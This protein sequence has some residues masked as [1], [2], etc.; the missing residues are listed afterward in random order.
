MKLGAPIVLA[1]ASP[2]R[3]EILTTLG[4]PFDVRPA[5]ADESVL[6][7]ESA[8][9]YVERIA[10]AKARIVRGALGED[11][12]RCVVLAADTT[13]VVDG[14]IL[15]KPEDDSDAVSMITRL[16][17]RSHEVLT[18][19]CS[20]AVDGT[21]RAAVV[22]T[23]VQMRALDADAVRRYVATGEGRDKAGA[24]GAQGIAS[25]FVTAIEGS[26][27]NVI[28]LPAVETLALLEAAGGVIEWP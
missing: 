6:V 17:G 19:V 23:V 2:R 7:G 4:V 22:R 5:D 9:A 14:D 26:F 24:Y 28:G 13:V 21:E 18:G 25:G 20:V 11:A 27:L 1:S 3:R 12:S 8:A 10:R 15:A 16:Q